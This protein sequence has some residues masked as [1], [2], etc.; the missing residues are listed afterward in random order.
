MEK[1]VILASIV[2][3]F[4]VVGCAPKGVPPEPSP[5]GLSDTLVG[6]AFRPGMVIVDDYSPPWDIA[7][8]EII[9]SI[10]PE[11][12]SDATSSI[13]LGLTVNSDGYI[14]YQGYYYDQRAGGWTPFEYDG[15]RFMVSDAPTNWIEGTATAALDFAAPFDRFRAGENYVL[16][17]ICKWDAGWRCGPRTLDDIMH[18]WTIQSFTLCGTGQVVDG[19]ACRASEGAITEL[20]F[21]GADDDHDGTMDCADTDCAAYPACAG[22][23]ATAAA[24]PA[25]VPD[26]D[27]TGV[28][29]TS[30][31]I[32]NDGRDNDCNGAID[33]MDSDCAGYSACAEAAAPACVPDKDGTGTLV[34]GEAS[35]ED[36]RDNDCD[37]AIDCADSDCV[38]YPACAPAPAPTPFTC[39]DTDAGNDPRTIGKIT[40]SNT[41][42]TR[43]WPDACS[44]PA[45]LLE[46]F[47]NPDGSTNRSTITCQSVDS[48]FECVRTWKGAYCGVPISCTETDAGL[49]ARAGGRTTSRNA[50][51]GVV[52]DKTDRCSS[53]AKLTEY[54][55]APDGFVEQQVS[56][57][58]ADI[59]PVFGCVADPPGAYCGVSRS[60]TDS[61]GGANGN[62][63]GRVN[64]VDASGATTS[65]T[66]TCDGS[67]AMVK[68]ASCT[69]T[70]ANFTVIDCTVSGLSCQI[71]SNGLA[72]CGVP[73]SCTDSD[74]GVDERTGG[75]VTAVDTS[76]RTTLYKD[77]CDGTVRVK[78]ASCTGTSANFTVIDCAASGLSCRT[79]FEGLAFC[80]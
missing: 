13:S 48:A 60:C 66:D 44:T 74:S 51:G 43:S 23:A 2:L 27:G 26:K 15:S 79:D 32:C 17:Y 22:A 70:S 28:P 29:F 75:K 25:C 36:S 1:L 62:V 38:A 3:I 37:G 12:F 49:D 80:A 73:P 59:D 77:T 52:D 8:G 10:T 69:G 41:T 20:C 57:A 42:W 67:G 18:R 35:C 63:G 16:V 21:N 64:V 24:A 14:Y 9:F 45:K 5:P 4:F 47:C 71:D 33:C 78:E 58:C 34:A 50:T 65:Y 19:A 56:I 55:C 31:I 6:Q 72:Y 7:T 68:E 54:F 61:D 39:T 76:G 40:R 30:E 11:G 53:P 46:Y